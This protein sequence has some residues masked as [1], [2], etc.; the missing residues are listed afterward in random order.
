MKQLVREL[1]EKARIAFLR[2]EEYRQ[3]TEKQIEDL[4]VE[5]ARLMETVV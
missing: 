5:N 3:D 1:Q 2:H 4:Q